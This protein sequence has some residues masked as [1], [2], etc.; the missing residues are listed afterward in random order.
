[1]STCSSAIVLDVSHVHLVQDGIS[2]VKAY[3]CHWSQMQITYAW[4]QNICKPYCLSKINENNCVCLHHFGF[5][6]RSAGLIVETIFAK[7]SSVA[8]SSCGA[9]F[10]HLYIET[11]TRPPTPPHTSTHITTH[12]HYRGGVSIGRPINRSFSSELLFSTA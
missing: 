3:A 2:Y 7:Q 8:F 6:N 11:H 10:L 1:M 5:I 4:K 9:F 12:I